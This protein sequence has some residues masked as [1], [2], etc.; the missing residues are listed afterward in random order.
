MGMRNMKRVEMITYPKE[1]PAAHGTCNRAKASALFVESVI[2]PTTLLITPNKRWARLSVK[3]RLVPHT[4][5]AVEGC[6]YAP[7]E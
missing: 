7:T 6:E 1:L 4:G 3:D 5:I 2:S